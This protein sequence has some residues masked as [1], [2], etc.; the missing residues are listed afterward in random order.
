MINQVLTALKDYEMLKNSNTVTVALSGGADSVAL[1]YCL[2]EL[3]ND[4]GIE[5]AA[6]HLNHHLRGSE[7]DRDQEFVERL[8]RALNVPLSVG[9]A[10]INELAQK[11]GQSIELAARQ[12]RYEFLNSV[13]VGVIA[14]AH[15]ASDSLET[16]LFNLTRGTGI[17]GLCG[18]PPKRDNFIRPLIYCTREQIENY[19][20]QNNI[21]YVTD[22]SNLTDDYT[23]NKIRHNA[24]PVL[25]QINR[26]LET[27]AVRTAKLLRED[28]RYLNDTAIKA[29]E[30]CLHNDKLCV[31]EL[32]KYDKAIV[33]R[34]LKAFY[35]KYY[36]AKLELL[37]VEQLYSICIGDLK[38]AT[39][40][41]NITAL[42]S[43]GFLTLIKG[44]KE[45]ENLFKVSY[46]IEKKEKVNSLL[47]NNA[48]DYDK[49]CGSIIV[50]VRK[51]GDKIRL[52][53][54]GVTKTLKK[55]FCENK[56]PVEYRELIPVIADEK[57]VI[58]VYDVGIDERVKIDNNTKNVL[59]IDKKA[60]DNN[61]K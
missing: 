44:K 41:Q 61:G 48:L 7:S 33:R 45:P 22:S 57:G 9:H 26:S 36:D 6:A 32:L 43:N 55:L 3:K 14:T 25:K 58:W 28:D 2:L 42:C 5:V 1:L 15:T 17:K 18:I 59:L 23:R 46:K 37:A 13:S 39:L 40:P 50:R 31:S 24:V 56:V 34:V 52:Q 47:L 12:K 16:M 27:N 4:L 29:L 19:C 30:D 8:C 11:T 35:E 49:I 54:R 38:N 21:E 60:G 51:E 10:D 20:S 53:N